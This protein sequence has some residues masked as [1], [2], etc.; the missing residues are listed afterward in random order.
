MLHKY[1][2]QHPLEERAAHRRSYG[3][4]RIAAIKWL[5]RY[6]NPSFVR[7]AASGAGPRP[8]LRLL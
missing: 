5:Q 7:A 3:G 8:P 2:V 4:A 6:L 1:L